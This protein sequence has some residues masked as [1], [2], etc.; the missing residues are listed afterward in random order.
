MERAGVEEMVGVDLLCLDETAIVGWL[1]S[2]P[3]TEH[4][5]VAGDEELMQVTEYS[6]QLGLPSRPT[7]ECECDDGCS[8]SMSPQEPAHEFRCALGGPR[9]I[10]G[11]RVDPDLRRWI[12]LQKQI[13]GDGGL[14][15]R[16]SVPE[17][18]VSSLSEDDRVEVRWPLAGL[19]PVAGH[20]HRVAHASSDGTGMYPVTVRVGAAEGALPGMTVRVG[21]DVP[22]AHAVWVPLAAILGEDGGRAVFK[23]VDEEPIRVERVDVQV[24]VLQDDWVSVAGPLSS[25]DRVATAGHM[26]LLSG[27]VV[28][29]AP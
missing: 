26:A 6:P 11:N 29:V 21:F 12:V 20:I 9:P 1:E 28:E 17:S 3:R 27:E 4:Q 22:L 18:L 13:E 25:A 16:I 2:D 14:E 24:G 23:L 15:V 10:Q 5:T 19:L 8:L 7:S